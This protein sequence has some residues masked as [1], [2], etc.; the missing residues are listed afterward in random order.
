MHC[1]GGFTTSGFGGG[2]L[3]LADPDG[4]VPG[5]VGPSSSSSSSVWSAQL[6]LGVRR[7]GSIN[8]V[9]ITEVLDGEPAV[10]SAYS[11]TTR[12]ATSGTVPLVCSANDG[13]AL[14]AVSG[15]APGPGLNTT[16][17]VVEN[18]TRERFGGGAATGALG[19][20][21]GTSGASSASTAWTLQGAGA[22][23]VAAVPWA[24]LGRRLRPWS[25]PE[26]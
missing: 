4:V 1:G 19:L 3:D 20:G 5:S 25:V 2:V 14:G 21:A 11:L 13:S 7:A 15:V 18:T 26:Y 23:G 22:R 10:G 16:L 12:W 9:T 24:G 8:G 17:E 6:R